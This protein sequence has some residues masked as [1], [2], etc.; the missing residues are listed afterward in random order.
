MLA[1]LVCKAASR[2]VCSVSA[3]SKLAFSRMGLRSLSSYTSNNITYSGG[4]ATEGQGGYYGSGGSRASLTPASEHRPEMLALAADVQTISSIMVEV[5]MLENLLQ[6]E[7][8]ENQGAIT[9]RSI[10]L[11][12]SIKKL[13][14]SP[15]VMECL[16]R[17]EIQGEPV[18]G[19]SSD[20]RDLVKLARSKINEC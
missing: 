2:Q 4:Q 6:S 18:W 15:D 16:N 5:E 20:E 10:E 7:T 9:S 12:G 1:R 14:T 17:L 13:M 3:K 8:E 19:L 11:R